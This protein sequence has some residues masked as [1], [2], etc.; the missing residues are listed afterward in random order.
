MSMYDSRSYTVAELV[1]REEAS[2]YMP[3]EMMS[4]KVDQLFGA[5][6]SGK[7]IICMYIDKL[8]RSQNDHQSSRKGHIYF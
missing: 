8:K 6:V 5:T 7:V 2:S 4:K 1:G 3:S